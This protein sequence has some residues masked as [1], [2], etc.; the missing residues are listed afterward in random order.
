MYGVGRSKYSC[1][2][3]CKCFAVLLSLPLDRACILF[4]SAAFLCSGLAWY[5]RLSYV[6]D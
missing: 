3:A 4:F 5:L 1:N 6:L 2:E